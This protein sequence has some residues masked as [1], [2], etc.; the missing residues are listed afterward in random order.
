MKNDLEKFAER[1]MPFFFMVVSLWCHKLALEETIGIGFTKSMFIH[2]S[3]ICKLCVS[4]DEKRQIALRVQ[5]LIKSNDP[6]FEK[7]Y[8][9]AKSLNLQADKLL[10]EHA[11][12]SGEIS[13]ENYNHAIEILFGNGGYCTI[14]PYWVLYGINDA[15]EKGA[16]RESFGDILRM[17]EELKSET[18]YPQ[19]AKEVFSLYFKKAMQV[20]DISYS[21]AT[22]IHPEEL[23]EIVFGCSSITAN[24]LEKRM[25]GCGIVRGNQ[26]YDVD[27]IF[28]RQIL[29]IFSD[30][31]VVDGEIVGRVAFEGKVCGP[32]KIVNDIDDMLKFKDGDILVSIQSSPALMSAIVRCSAI[33]TDEGGIMCHASVISRELKKP[34]IIGTKIATKV[35]KDGDMV[36]VDAEKGIV[37]IIN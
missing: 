11:G 2:E 30:K 25:N 26:P 27:Y 32:V 7:W 6:R 37:R 19:I 36:E 28:D 5:E 9:K 12:D 1:K 24:E 29:D 8:E 34:C 18:R 16:E 4:G 23:R 14:L 22:C 13:L 3:G 15:I 10:L 31:K 33:V 21:L 35:L 20:L 17:Y